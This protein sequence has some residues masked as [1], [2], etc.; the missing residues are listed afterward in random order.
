MDR[1]ESPATA[2]VAATPT[3]SEIHSS[4]AGQGGAPGGDARCIVG[5]LVFFCLAGFGKLRENLNV[6]N[7]S[8]RNI[9]VADD[10]VPWPVTWILARYNRKHRWCFSRRPDLCC[11]ACCFDQF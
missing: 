3:R 9:V 5:R 1:A 7:H 10:I 8:I 4:G 6:Y 11:G 2:D